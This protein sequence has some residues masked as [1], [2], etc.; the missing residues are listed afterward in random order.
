MAR[1]GDLV[2]LLPTKIESVW[3]QVLGWNPGSETPLPASDAAR[4]HV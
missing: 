1:P 2:V 4:P 3:G